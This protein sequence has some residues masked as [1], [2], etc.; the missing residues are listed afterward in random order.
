MVTMDLRRLLVTAALPVIFMAG[1][2]TGSHSETPVDATEGNSASLIQPG[3]D[4]QKRLQ[5]ALIA[6]KPGDVIEL[7][8]GKFELKGTLSLDVNNVTLRGQGRDKTVFELS[9][10]EAGTGGEGLL[11]TAGPIT[12]EDLAIEN[13]KGDA[14]KVTGADGVTIRRVRTEWTGGP[15]DTNGS[16]GIYPVQCKNVLIEECIAI[17]ASDA[18]IYVGQSQN[19]IVR[20]NRATQNVAGIEIENSI[21]A[22]V[23]ENYAS[24]NAGGIL[25]FSLPNLPAKNGRGCRVF[26]NTIEENNHPNFAGEGNIVAMVPPGTGL[27]VMAYD[28]VE[29]FDN[30]FKNNG[31]VNVGILSY[32]VTEKKYDDADYDPYPEGIAIH[33]NS[34]SG[35]G[36]KPAGKM[37]MTLSALVGGRFP[38]IA[39]DGIIDDKKLV[40]GKLPAELQIS[41]YDNGDAD[42]ANL[43]L[44]NFDPVR[45]KFP[46]VSRDLAPHANP[47]TAL[48]PVQLRQV[49]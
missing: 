3:A 43:D 47:R 16:Y 33:H 35:G 22:D 48:R 1:C 37:G 34:F 31:T 21:D 2:G 40:D 13:A 6:A 45:F 49:Q 38:D 15:K 10:Q 30:T 23:Y 12:I 14:L 4:I 20:G 28:D 5:R 25:V 7:A 17:G 36:D 9:G 11:V 29:V 46:K 42:F 8:A 26:K 32:L 27:M 19:I 39:Y 41:I 24:N 18:G 44:A